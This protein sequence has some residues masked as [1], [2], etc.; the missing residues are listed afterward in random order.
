MFQFKLRLRKSEYK[1]V[2]GHIYHFA[3]SFLGIYFGIYLYYN[4]E[5][6]S[7]IVSPIAIESGI[8]L[9]IW[10]I[11]IGQLIHIFHKYF[12]NKY[13]Y[14][15]IKNSQRIFIIC[16]CIVI[17]CIIRSFNKE[18]NIYGVIAILLGKFI[19]IDT[20]V[21]SFKEIFSNIIPSLKNLIR[22]SKTRIGEISMFIVIGEISYYIIIEIIKRGRNHVGISALVATIVGLSICYYCILKNKDK[23][24]YNI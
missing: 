24:S 21:N 1:F 22:F 15:T 6:L 23:N 5:I 10:L 7:N 16:V 8:A 2:S 19:W 12:N 14:Y 4:R 9:A 3:S 17:I 20:G 11:F 18:D 13:K